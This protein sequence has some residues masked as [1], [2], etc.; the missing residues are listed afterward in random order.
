MAKK[1]DDRVI[2]LGLGANLPGARGG[3]PRE[4]LLAALEALEAEGVRVLARSR[5]YDSAAWPDPSQPR[6]WNAVAAVEAALDPVALLALL[7]RV[8]AACGR[9]RGAR[10]APRTVDLDLLDYDG[11]V[12]P[13]PDG[14]ILPHPR[15]AERGFVLLPL[16]EVAP[17]WRH[18]VTGFTVDALI[19]ALPADEDVR[20]R[21]L[22]PAS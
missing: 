18:P 14:P 21:S 7:Q 12:R 13:G 20:P 6:Y 1:G 10:N 17:D 11:M 5:W 9:V 15:M 16:R 2:L 3:S 22:P 8:E 4:T 19:S